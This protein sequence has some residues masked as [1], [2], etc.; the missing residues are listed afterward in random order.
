MQAA[1]DQAHEW[2]ACEHECERKTCM[3]QVR[4]MKQA[5]IGLSPTRR[6]S[7]LK[8]RFG[9]LRAARDQVP[10]PSQTSTLLVD[11]HA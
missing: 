9:C 10:A 5:C 3:R 8:E 11:H 1:A 6:E 2:K 4:S 7:V